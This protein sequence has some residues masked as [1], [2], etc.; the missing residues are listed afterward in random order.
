MIHEKSPYLRQ[1]AE[2]PVD[3]YPWGEEAFAKAK[4]LDRPILLSIGYSTCHYCHLMEKETFSQKVVAD[5]LNSHFISIKVDREEL[6]EVDSLYMEFASALSPQGVGWPL[7]VMLTS[8][9]K[10]FLAVSYLPLKGAHGMVGF[11]EFIEEIAR[12]WKGDER[13]ALLEQ[14]DKIVELFKNIHHV[15]SEDLPTEE[16]V[17]KGLE[18]ILA[19]AD[20]LY[21]GMKG[22]PKFPLG[23][24]LLF[25]L[26]VATTKN[27]S[28]ALYYVEKSLEMMSRG[29]IRDVLGGGFSRYSVDERWMVPHFE[30]M[31]YDNALLLEAY[32]SYYALSRDEKYARVAHEIG[33][34]LIRRMSEPGLAFFTAEDADSEGEEGRFYTWR[35]EE[36]YSLLPIEEAKL[37]CDFYNVKKEGNFKGNSI[38]FQMESYEEFAKNR[39]LDVDSL[40]KS[41][42]SARA[43]LFEER[44]KRPKPFRDDK[45]LA[46]WNGLVIAALAKASGFLNRPDFL[47]KAYEAMDYLLNHH[48]H[49]G[50][51]LRTTLGGESGSQGVLDD[52]AFMIRALITLFEMGGDFK[53]LKKALEL[54]DFL[55]QKFRSPDGS[56]YSTEEK[57]SVLVK[58]LRIL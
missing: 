32:A 44:E 31:I 26:E 58:A 12:I 45:V 38:L 54:C 57:D 10:P 8:D 40:K 21:G 23:E 19:L 29:G 25:L 16:D 27:E 49:E 9:L 18:A 22:A 13:V 52:Y 47:E 34:Y 2:N 55:D 24:Q 48:C 14:G 53:W 33:D 1:H 15:H 36:I 39:H 5:C 43:K 35:Y 37:F 51:V 3:W 6:P 28:R 41:L 46:G 42:E 20:P 56:Y 11:Q 17:F 30:K 7:N 50:R 4:E